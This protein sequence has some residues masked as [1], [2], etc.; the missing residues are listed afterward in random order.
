MDKNT[1]KRK[2]R[3]RISGSQF[4]KKTGLSK[5]IVTKA[6]KSL[7]DRHLM[8][9]SDFKGN[10]LMYASD[11]KGKKHLYFRPIAPELSAPQTSAQSAPVPVHKG[12][13]NKTN[14]TKPIRTGRKEFSGHIGEIVSGR[15]FFNSLAP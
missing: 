4:R 15:E 1:G 12:D 11:R 14:Y 10:P 6:V 5:R 9:V 3:D 13:H 7:V 8:E 2:E